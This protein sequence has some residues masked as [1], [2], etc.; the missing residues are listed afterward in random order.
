MDLQCLTSLPRLVR[1]VAT[2][3]AGVDAELRFLVIFIPVIIIFVIVISSVLDALLRFQATA[4]QALQEAAE[5]LLVTLFEVRRSSIPLRVATCGCRYFL[6]VG[7]LAEDGPKSVERGT[8]GKKFPTTCKK[9]AI[10]ATKINLLKI[11]R[12]DPPLQD[13][14]L[15]AIHAKRVTVMPKD[16]ALARRIRGKD[17]VIT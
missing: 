1:E 11:R 2:E 9:F 14:M 15:L 10:F 16:M 5:A 13:S 6:L 12:P 7:I 17:H 3:V 4:I 8:N